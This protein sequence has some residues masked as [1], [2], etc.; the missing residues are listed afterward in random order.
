[1]LAPVALS[2]LTN[3]SCKI[4]GRIPD[5]VGNL[6]NLLD[7]RI[8][9]NNL[10]GWIPSTI[11]NLRKLHHF[12]LTNNKLTGFPQQLATCLGNITSLR[13][14]HLG[15]NKLSSNIPPSLGNLQDLVVLD[16]SSNKM[17]GFLPPEIG[18]LKAV[19]L[20]D[21]TMNQFSNE[22]L[23]KIGGLQTLVHLSLKHNK[24]QGSIPDSMSNM[25]GLEFLDLSHNNISGIIPMS[26]E[27]LKNLK[28][29]NVS[30]NKLYG[31]IPSSSPFK[32]LPSQFFINNEAL[33]GSSRFSVP[34]CPTSSKHRSNNKK[35]LVL[36]LL[37]GI[38]L[39]FVPS[40]F[41]LLWKRYRKGKRALQQPD[42][43]AA[44]TR[45]R[46]SYYE[47]LQATDVLSESNRIGSGSFGSV[48]KGVLI[49]GTAIAVKVFNLQ[50]DAAFKRFDME[51]EVLRSLRH[52]NLV[53][54]NT[55]CSN[56]D[57]RL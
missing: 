55:S 49:S 17:V 35:V 47:L 40:I 27:K 31:E 3:L 4:Q 30:V 42:S 32:N 22:I 19:T 5:E 13:E 43:L 38:A 10:V 8:S 16:L 46:I 20:I 18:N 50:L 54:V 14:I 12:D 41:V 23:R 6:S 9:G 11:G 51:C 44:I 25:V 34:P 48:Y 1:M 37:L 26:L 57:L 52:R 56:L 45:E 39:V 29:F 15:S 36:F 24:L 2:A 53:K 7:L 33:C 21:L 28:Y